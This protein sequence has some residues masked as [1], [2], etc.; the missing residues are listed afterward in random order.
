VKEARSRPLSRSKKRCRPSRAQVQAGG[1][2]RHVV[3][4]IGSGEPLGERFQVPHPDPAGGGRNHR[5]AVGRQKDLPGR[6]GVA[7]Q[8]VFLPAGGRV[9]HRHPAAGGS[10]QPPGVRGEQGVVRPPDREVGRVQFPTD[11]DVPGLQAGRPVLVRVAG[12]AEGGQALAVR[13]ESDGTHV[14][15]VAGQPSNRLAGRRVEQPD[16]ARNPGCGPRSADFRDATGDGDEP[17]PRL[18][19]GRR[20]APDTPARAA[21]SWP[22]AASQVRTSPGRDRL[23]RWPSLPGLRASPGFPT[24]RRPLLSVLKAR[25]STGSTWPASCSRACPVTRSQG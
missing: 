12:A 13:G 4:G 17:A 25:Y 18:P 2:E 6:L 15:P 10:H 16:L 24:E 21:S 8:G 1:G 7:C 22:P 23:T 5:L 11:G 3:A 14:L 20:T 9:P 19:G